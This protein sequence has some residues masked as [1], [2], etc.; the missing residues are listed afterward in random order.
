MRSGS[1]PYC[2]DI[3]SMT[4]VVQMQLGPG[5]R[6]RGDQRPPFTDGVP[7]S[8]RHLLEQRLELGRKVVQRVRA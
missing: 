5:V 1:I 7:P 3:Q 8:E 6:R 2:C 4:A